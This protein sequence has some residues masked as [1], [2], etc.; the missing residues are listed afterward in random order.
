MYEM[1]IYIPSQNQS[2]KAVDSEYIP[3][4]TVNLMWKISCNPEIVP[5]AEDLTQR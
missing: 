1:S 4:Q 2:V 3:N 5:R